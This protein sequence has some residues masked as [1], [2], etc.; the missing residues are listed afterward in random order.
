MG[1]DKR[2]GVVSISWGAFQFTQPGWAATVSYPAQHQSGGRFN[3]RS[4][5]GLRLRKPCLYRSAASCFNSRSPDGLRHRVQVRKV[6]AQRFNSRSPDGLRHR[7]QVR[8]VGAQRFNSRSPDGLRQRC[9]SITRVRPNVS[10]HA[11]R[12]GC[13]CVT[14]IILRLNNVVS[15][16]AARMGCD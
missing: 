14:D 5:D 2:S 8:K 6:G 15:I 3:S 9:L 16:H 12:M 1:C 11:A 13:D 7:V 4:P 10:I